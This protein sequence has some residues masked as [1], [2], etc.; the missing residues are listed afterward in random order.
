MGISQFPRV[1]D[2]V[3]KMFFVFPKGQRHSTYND[4]DKEIQQLTHFQKH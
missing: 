4:V 2:D 3:L 1:K